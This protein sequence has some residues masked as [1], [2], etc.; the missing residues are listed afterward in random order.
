MKRR[1]KLSILAI[2]I[3]ALAAIFL[4]LFMASRPP[5][6]VMTDN[7]TVGLY[8]T[9]HLSLSEGPI[10][11]LPPN[12]ELKYLDHRIRRQDFFWLGAVKVEYNGQEG[13]V[14]YRYLSSESREDVAR[15]ARF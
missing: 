6:Y 1:R 13:W 5:R 2:I 12:Q 10:L 9:H 11:Q 15:A 14:D 7:R 4:I 8:R 3:I